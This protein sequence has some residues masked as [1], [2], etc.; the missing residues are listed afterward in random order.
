MT[1]VKEKSTLKSTEC[2]QSTWKW[3]ILKKHL[4]WFSVFFLFPA[5]ESFLRAKRQVQMIEKHASRWKEKGNHSIDF[6]CV[7]LLFLLERWKCRMLRK[8]KAKKVPKCSFRKNTQNILILKPSRITLNNKK[9]ITK[10]TRRRK[11]FAKEI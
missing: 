8:R 7:F 9:K 3:K 2:V 11:I 1:K 6:K 4:N 5:K 10:I